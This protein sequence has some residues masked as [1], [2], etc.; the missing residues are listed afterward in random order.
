MPF[1]V[2]SEERYERR[3]I[4]ILYVGTLALL[5]VLLYATYSNM[6]QH[7]DAARSIRLYNY[8]MLELSDLLSDLQDQETGARGYLLTQDTTFL[9]PYHR[10][11]LADGGRLHA[12]DSLLTDT[13]WRVQLHVLRI[14]CNEAEEQLT[15]LVMRMD[16]G[17]LLTDTAVAALRASKISMDGVRDVQGRIMEQLRRERDSFLSTERSTLV[18]TPLALVLYSALAIAATALL[19][20]RLSRALRNTERTK[21]TLHLNLAQ[22]D[23]EVGQRTSVQ[24][25]LQKVL[26][27][28]PNGIM[29]FRSI[30]DEDGAVIDFEFLA[31]NRQANAIAERNDLVGKRLLA[32]MPEHFTAGLFDAFV[33]VVGTGI[34]F[35]KDLHY[36]GNGQNL[37]FSTHAVRFEDGFMIT[38]ANITDQ[39]RAQEVNAE[40]DRIELTGQITR[41]VAHEV[42]N[43]LTNIHLAV[44]Q[45]HDEVHDRDELVQP[46][47]QIIDRNLK[48][49]GTL[50][51]EMLES[52]KKRELN[53]VPC[54]MED[55]V[56][57]A[58]KHVADRLALKGIRGEMGLAADLPEVMVDRELLNLAITNIAIN[59]VEAM[60]PGHGQLRM[61]AY[62]LG[63]EVLLEIEDNGRGIPQK[64]LS[65]LFEPFYSGRPGGLGLGLTTTRSILNGHKIKLEVRSAVAEG[66]TFTLRFPSEVFVPEKVSISS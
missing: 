27:T 54:K 3:M 18:G 5:G 2:R 41:T 4:V 15:D 51:N 35:R 6:R 20:W 44:E 31:A 37:W 53:L 32:E 48:R 60:E 46:F 26:D 9:A 50:I 43:P 33:H 25:M 28:S 12:A 64:N 30:K 57:N 16:S 36:V 58:M 19:F 13:V 17:A 7:N 34:P 61:G 56:Q 59:A 22:L 29:V 42:R 10:G 21:Q 65:R 45:L 40:A 49:I 14:R 23:K 1:N 52:S 39:K 62:R 47:F 55:I 24:D 66:S 11:R 38:L 63:E 8:G